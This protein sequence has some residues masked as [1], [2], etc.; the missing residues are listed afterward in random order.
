MPFVSDGYDVIG[1]V[2]GCAATLEALLVQLGYRLRG[3][4]WMHRT[5]QAVFVGDLINR[6]PDTVGVVRIVAAMVA[7]G[8]AIA[9]AGNHE[10][11]WSRLCAQAN[12]D[13]GSRPS[14]ALWAALGPAD[15]EHISR[16]CMSLPLFAELG[17]LRVVHAF[18]DTTVAERLRGVS[19]ADVV[20]EGRHSDL[21]QDVLLLTNGPTA[22]LPG[23]EQVVRPDGATFSAVL[24]RWWDTDAVTW[25]DATELGRHMPGHQLLP[26]PLPGKATY[27]DPAPLFFGHYWHDAANP[28]GAVQ[29]TTACLDFRCGSVNVPDPH[30]WK[31]PP[32]LAAY[33]WCGERRLSPARL[34]V[35]PQIDR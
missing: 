13:P 35:V 32:S 11:S 15:R 20:A 3:G 8:S 9:V 16:F 6:G 24:Q 7:A 5:R 33:R 31:A 25:E 17:P 28:A 34:T 12:P 29:E 2:H 22:A 30:T 10:V 1:D 27:T 26:E 19:M 21:G 23:G 4:A 14:G 18:W